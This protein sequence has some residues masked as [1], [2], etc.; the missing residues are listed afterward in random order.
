MA[1]ARH[2]CRGH[3]RELA[4]GPSDVDDG[5]RARDRGLDIALFSTLTVAVDD[6]SVAVR[7]GSLPLFR[8]SFR[9]AVIH[10]LR[11]VRNS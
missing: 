6:D 5:R 8:R 9:W 2:V 11:V 1:R 4:S 3:A 10:S 7:F